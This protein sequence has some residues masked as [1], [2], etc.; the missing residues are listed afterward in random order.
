MPVVTPGTYTLAALTSELNTDPIAMG[1]AAVFASCSS[2][3]NLL[4]QNPEPVG[5]TGGQES[6]FRRTVLAEDMV[7]G[8]VLTEYAALAQSNRDYLNLLFGPGQVK[9]GDTNVRTQ[10]GLIFPAGTSR[11]NMLAAAQKLASRAE[12]LWGDGFTVSAQ[13]VCQALGR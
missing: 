8:I 6:I 2:L 3:A 10:L 7:A 1:Y 11:T 5:V 9:T 13:T 4:N 12:A